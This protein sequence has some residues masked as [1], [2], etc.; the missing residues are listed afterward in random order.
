[1]TEEQ[2]KTVMKEMLSGCN[3]A[4][5]AIA[6]RTRLQMNDFILTLVVNEPNSQVFS[7]KLIGLNLALLDLG[8]VLQKSETPVSSNVH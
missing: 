1:M 2:T 6:E 4:E 8:A 7:A 3:N 5:K